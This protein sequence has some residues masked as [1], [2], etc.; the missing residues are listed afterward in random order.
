MT[1]KQAKRETL[2]ELEIRFLHAGVKWSE[3][4]RWYWEL[5]VGFRKVK[6]ERNH[7]WAMLK[8]LQGTSY[9]GPADCD[10]HI[11]WWRQFCERHGVDP[12]DFNVE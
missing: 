5:L 12:K 6:T 4:L 2:E 8:E 7:Y 11:T 3:L 9:S 1:D 10:G